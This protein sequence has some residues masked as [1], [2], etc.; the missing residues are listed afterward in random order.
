[1]IR[2]SRRYNH[3]GAYDGHGPHLFPQK[4]RALK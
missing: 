2:L 1:M 4:I 3:I